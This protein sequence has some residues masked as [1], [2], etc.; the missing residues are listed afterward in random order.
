MT[1][2]NKLNKYDSDAKIYDLNYLENDYSDYE[3]FI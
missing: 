1:F 3:H 2:E